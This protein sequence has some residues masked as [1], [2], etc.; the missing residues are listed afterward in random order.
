LRELALMSSFRLAPSPICA[1]LAQN[2]ETNQVR[3]QTIIHA[4]SC[5]AEGEVGDVITAGVPVP[6][7]DT[8]WQQRAWAVSNSVFSNFMLNEPRGG[9]FCHVNF[10]LP[11]SDPLADAAWIIMEPEATTPMLGSN[12]I[13]VTVVLLETGILP[14]QK[15]STH[16]ILQTLSGLLSVEVQCAEGKV[17][18]V[19]V[20]NLLRFAAQLDV[21]LK[22]PGLG[23]LRVDTTFGRDSYVIVDAVDLG[24]KIQPHEA[25]HIVELG[26]P[27]AKAA[28][29]QLECN[30]PVQPDW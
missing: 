4:V 3:D 5:H 18:Q 2:R 26:L 10:L 1:N 9:V 29:D 16:L 13:C 14:I 23:D 21:T 24:F 11:P 19:T 27:I 7:G 15:P 22:V 25:H 6:P 20:E 12:S 8:L 17:T 28:N 30:H